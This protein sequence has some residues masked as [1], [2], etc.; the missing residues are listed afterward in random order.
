MGLQNGGRGSEGGKKSAHR[1]RNETEEEGKLDCSKIFYVLN[2]N[3]LGLN[4]N[5]LFV[6]SAATDRR[7]PVKLV[8]QLS[9]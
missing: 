6:V 7:L 3:L 4:Q 2:R 9:V 1:W 8:I 5:E